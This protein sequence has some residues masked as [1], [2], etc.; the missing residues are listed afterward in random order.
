MHFL[1]IISVINAQ[2]CESEIKTNKL[3]C[4]SLILVR[5]QRNVKNFNVQGLVHE[6]YLCH[7]PNV[8]YVPDAE[9]ALNYCSSMFIPVED[10]HAQDKRL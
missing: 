1:Q 8:S 7:L 9:L 6:L 5:F 2:L 4:Q 10:K 3:K